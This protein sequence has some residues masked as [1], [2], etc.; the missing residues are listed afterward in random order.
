[1][2]LQ[3]IESIPIPYQNFLEKDS[4]G[5]WYVWENCYGYVSA[6]N[7]GDNSPI[8]YKSREEAHKVLCERWRE[9]LRNA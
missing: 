2:H 4:E 8:P 5:N 3:I 1:M 9:S 7:N 6:R